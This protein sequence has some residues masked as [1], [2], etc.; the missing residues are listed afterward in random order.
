MYGSEETMNIKHVNSG[1]EQD[2]NSLVGLYWREDG[3]SVRER[4][5]DQFPKKNPGDGNHK[6]RSH[7]EMKLQIAE[8]YQTP[9]MKLAKTPFKSYWGIITC[10]NIDIS[11][12]S[13]LYLCFSRSWLYLFMY[14]FHT[15]RYVLSEKNVFEMAILKTIFIS[16]I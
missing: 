15:S 12:L 16:D 2:N 9:L 8:K 4:K 5:G 11:N 13:I 6:C 1:I 10:Y 3:N 14:L 7:V